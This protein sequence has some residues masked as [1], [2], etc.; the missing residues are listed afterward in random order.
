MIGGSG[1]IP[2]ALEASVNHFH[3]TPGIMDV[4]RARD[5]PKRDKEWGPR[6][7]GELMGSLC[8]GDCHPANRWPPGKC[9]AVCE[10]SSVCED[11]ENSCFLEDRVLVDVL[12]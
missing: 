11:H 10:V 1:R 7:P 12:V 2:T 5:G 9:L 8:S 3:D 6:F 4:L